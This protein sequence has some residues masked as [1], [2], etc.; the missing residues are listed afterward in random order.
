MIHDLVVRGI[1]GVNDWGRTTLRDIVV[2]VSLWVDTRSVVRT[3]D[4]TLGVDYSVMATY[5]R[6]LVETSRRLIVEALAKD[7]ANLYL[8]QAGIR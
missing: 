1:L 5:I 4:L 2:N 7:I 3:D 8:R 6:N